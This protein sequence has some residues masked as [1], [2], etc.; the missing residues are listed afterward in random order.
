MWLRGKSATEHTVKHIVKHVFHGRQRKYVIKRYWYRAQDDTIQTVEHI[1]QHFINHCCK[2]WKGMMGN[3][4]LFH[5]NTVTGTSI[6]LAV[7]IAEV[8]CRGNQKT[9]MDLSGGWI[10]SA[11]HSLW[12][13]PN[14]QQDW[15]A[16]WNP[17]EM[18]ISRTL[19]FIIFKNTVTDD[20]H[21]CTQR[22]S[23]APIEKCLSEKVI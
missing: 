2:A 11:W 8:L 20:T 4:Q 17:R 22:Q 10:I 19:V 16:R 6:P 23:T 13:A 18:K 12:F 14:W 21:S 9:L 3:I 1:L 7:S 5:L 15:C